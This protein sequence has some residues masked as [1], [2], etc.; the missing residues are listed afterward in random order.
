VKSERPFV[1][2]RYAKRL[3]CQ[4]FDV[5]FYPA[6][7]FWVENS[8]V[9]RKTSAHVFRDTTDRLPTTAAVGRI[10]LRANIDAKS[11]KND[12]KSITKKASAKRTPRVC[13]FSTDESQLTRAQKKA[14]LPLI[15]TVPVA[16]T[17]EARRAVPTNRFSI[18]LCAE[19][20]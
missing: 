13:S 8:V 12:A 16:T 20:Q 2:E 19:L 4:S 3:T 11:I 9:S 5:H 18:L 15:A 7:Q 6:P 1:F 17:T 14:R 10:I